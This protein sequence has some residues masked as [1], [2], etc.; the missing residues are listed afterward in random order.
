MPL[1]SYDL[2]RAVAF[3]KGAFQ[4]E[5]SQALN[6]MRVSAPLFVPAESG[7]CAHIGEVQ[8]SLW[9]EKTISA[10]AAAGVRLL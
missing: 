1:E 5:F 4:E 7:L 3:I 6:L 2:Q 8:A 10:C 9:D